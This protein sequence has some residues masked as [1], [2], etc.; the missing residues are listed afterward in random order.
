MNIIK[1]SVIPFIAISMVIVASCV[2]GA[3]YEETESFLNVVFFRGDIEESPQKLSVIG[4]GMEE[5]IY[6]DKASASNTTLPLNPGAS[7]VSFYVSVN[8]TTDI[9]TFNYSSEPYMYSKEC[10]YTW[11][12]DIMSVS[13]TNNII[14]SVSV[15]KDK[16]TIS[17]EEN[18]RIYY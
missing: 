6:E 17:D 10:G 5:Y 13:S 16:A 11:F 3:C 18:I 14:D 15:T 7:S 1:K 4:S 8:D 2:D 9:V 12:Y